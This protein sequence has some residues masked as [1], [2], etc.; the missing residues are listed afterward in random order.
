MTYWQLALKNLLRRPGRSALTV[1]AI[2][3]AIAA[4]VSLTSISWGFEASWQHANDL[5]GTD[6][7]VTRLASENTLPAPFAAGAVQ[8][9]IAA[10]PHVAQVAGLLS[11]LLSVGDMPPMFVFG[12]ERGS[13]LWDHLR[14]REG[15]W[16]RDDAEQAV[17]LGSLASELIGKK[18]GDAIQI[19]SDRYTIIGVFDSP[20]LVESGA[21][22]MTLAQAQRLN[23]KP[24]KVNIL[25]VKL[26]AGASA[27]DAAAIREGVR[28]AN[29]G[30]AAITS[31]Q[32]VQQNAI[33]RISKAMSAATI[34]IAGLVGALG[35]L[36]TMLM[37]VN[38]RTR[39]IGVL[40][41]L[42]WRRSRV[43]LL[44]LMESMA[45]TSAGG[46]IGV[47]LGALGVF[48]LEHMALLRG[49]IDGVFTPGLI[50]AALGLSIGLGVA[51]GLYPA[52]RAARM[53]PNAALR[54]E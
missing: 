35:V 47:A 15:R 42:G 17:M 6:L 10:M 38:E 34:L 24:G 18:V 54:H 29:P 53:S 9:R 25:N 48:V 49:K 32:L 11:E 2:A 21:V 3:I 14:L 27:S 46:V 23:D 7:I 5:R 22:M 52:L 44:I 31:G 30:F 26:D 39:E 19:E 37:S 1:S 13:F 33:V 51:G 50:L 43:V 12:W 45:V 4:I 28:A 20:A 8:A 16:P 40:L 36:N 41:A